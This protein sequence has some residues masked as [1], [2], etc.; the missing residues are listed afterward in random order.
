MSLHKH[1]N[2]YVYVV[3]S[4]NGQTKNCRVHL[5]IAT[6]FLGKKTDGLQINHID[7]D[8][9]NNSPE[10]LEYCTQSENMKHAYK[11]GL[12][13]PIGKKVINL[14]TKEIYENLTD[15]ART[16]SKAKCGGEMI[17][18]VCRGERSHYKNKRFAFYS[19]YIN[20]TIP[21]YKGKTKRKASFSLWV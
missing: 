20:N 11:N 9:S 16:F 17:A 14:E 15:A 2:G 5:L 12:Q 3:L 7:G 21:E 19:D 13:K 18:R 10:N 6:T 4:K 8:K 1:K